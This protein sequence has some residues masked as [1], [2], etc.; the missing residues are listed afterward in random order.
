MPEELTS[1]EMLEAVSA[2]E[3]DADENQN[4]T[5]GAVNGSTPNDELTT[6]ELLDLQKYGKHSVEYKANGKMVRESLEQ[7]L[8]RSSQGYNYAQLVNEFGQ[9]EPSYK[10]QIEEL[11][12]KVTGLSK[13]EQF[14]KYALENPKWA[15]YVSNMWDNKAQY[16]NPDLDPDDPVTKKIA[17]ME[18]R[19]ESVSNQYGEKLSKF[20]K[21]VSDQETAKM[22]AGFD[23]H[24]KSTVEKYSMFDF[25]K[26]DESG[27]DV[28]TYVME[29]MVAKNIPE[30]DV[31]FLHLYH[32]Q[33][34][35]SREQSMLEKHAK[36]TQKRTKEGFIGKSS[37]PGYA[38]GNISNVSSMGWNEISE[39]A[40][41]E[42]GLI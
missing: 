35:E 24:I 33:I 23:N 19:L 42:M 13:W 26:K 3:V 21:I 5:V 40:K 1:G 30:F 41:K 14:D 2:I 25:D 6:Q 34:V 16:S 20:D 27:K 39:L 32:D 7:A 18:K 4:K 31:A 10:K 22:E 12:G 9:K 36:Q 17:E 15:E 38:N 8:Q 29:H 11:T 37:T 28:K